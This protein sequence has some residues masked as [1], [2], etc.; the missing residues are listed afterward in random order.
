MVQTAGVLFLAVA[1]GCCILYRRK[2]WRYRWDGV[3]TLSVGLQGVGF[4]LCAPIQVHYL[5][6][7]LFTLTGHG[8]LRDYFGHLCF[9]S[10]AAALIYAV[11]YRIAPDGTIER[12]MRRIEIP[13]TF[14]AAVMFVAIL[15]A[16][17][18]RHYPAGD[19]FNVRP[20]GWLRVYWF[21][22]GL[23]LL[24]LLGYLIYLLRILRQDPRS[25]VSA[26]LYITASMIGLVSVVATMCH[27]VL[28]IE[29]P[30]HWF[31]GPLSMSSGIAI[32]VAAWSWRRNHA[33]TCRQEPCTDR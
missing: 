25:R 31:W 17:P 2:S 30:L 8:H 20:D 32:C 19:L 13:A 15:E 6:R 1:A 28:S 18:L 26:N 10:S 12:F 16:R 11:A 5:G 22:Y 23:I 9:I 21:T 27:T 33:A 14:A 4:M 3:V 29:V 7:W 24:Y